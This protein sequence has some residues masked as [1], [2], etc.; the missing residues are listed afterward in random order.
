M[1]LPADVEVVAQLPL[2]RISL[3]VPGPAPGLFCNGQE[4]LSC[5]VRVYKYFPSVASV[6]LYDGAVVVL[7][8]LAFE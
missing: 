5:L 8:E 1:L 2:L 4:R 7:T 6:D 3:S